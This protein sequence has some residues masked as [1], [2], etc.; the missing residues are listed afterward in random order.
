MKKYA[1]ISGK[2]IAEGAFG[3][4]ERDENVSDELNKKLNS[5][6]KKEKAITFSI[7]NTETVIVPNQ[8]FS[9]GYNMVCLHIEYEI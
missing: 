4:L 7:I 3:S 6:L 2:F 8:D 1:R 9:I 5:F